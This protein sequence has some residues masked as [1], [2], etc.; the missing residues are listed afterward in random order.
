M[1]LAHLFEILRECG[2]QKAFR[3]ACTGTTEFIRVVG[4]QTSE[5]GSA[6]IA[7]PGSVPYD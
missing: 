2:K 5:V 1:R 3:T 7:V 4:G 6:H